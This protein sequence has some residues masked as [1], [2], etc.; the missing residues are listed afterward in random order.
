VVIMMQPTQDRGGEDLAP[1]VIWWNWPT[2][3]FWKLLLDPL[4]W[5]GSIKVV[6]I[7]VEYPVE[8]LLMQ[9]KQKV[10]ALTPHTAQKP[11]TDGICSRSVI[12]YCEN[13]DATCARNT[14]E[15]CP[16]LAIVI[17]DEVFRPCSKRCSFSQLLRDPGVCGSS[18]DA[19]IDQ[20]EEDRTG[21]PWLFLISARER[22]RMSKVARTALPAVCSVCLFHFRGKNYLFVFPALSG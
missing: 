16:K 12:R 20:Q 3:R 4:M 15:A 21:L 13:L 8:L 9:D 22:A 10:E 2:M 6:H 5:S 1:C 19:H 7:G 11:F 14:G 17:P 18:C